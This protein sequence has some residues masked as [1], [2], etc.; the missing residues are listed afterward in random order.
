[1]MGQPSS[2]RFDRASRFA[3]RNCDNLTILLLI[4]FRRAYLQAQSGFGLFEIV[5]IQADELR[6]PKSTGK[7]N[8]Q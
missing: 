8:K 6:P 2:E 5:D 7:A 3:R 1:M 4:G